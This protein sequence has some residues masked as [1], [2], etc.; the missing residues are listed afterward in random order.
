MKLYTFRVFFH[1]DVKLPPEYISTHED[2]FDLA[3]LLEKSDS[4][5][6]YNVITDTYYCGWLEDFGFGPMKKWL[7]EYPKTIV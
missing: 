2:V 4:V 1:N 7:R 6:A 3:W 5:R